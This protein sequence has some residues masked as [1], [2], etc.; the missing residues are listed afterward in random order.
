[1]RTHTFTRQELFDLVWSAMSV[2]ARER[3]ARTVALDRGPTTPWVSPTSAEETMV[4]CALSLG[5]PSNRIASNPLTPSGSDEQTSMKDYNALPMLMSEA[6]IATSVRELIGEARSESHPD[7][8][9]VAESLVTMIGRQSSHYRPF[10]PD[11]AKL[12]DDWVCDVWSTESLPLFDALAT[13]AANTASSRTKSL[14]ERARQ[15]P[16]RAISDI[17]TETLSQ[18]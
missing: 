9:L 14:L 7:L 17:A 6:E 12:I 11:V 2:R 13:L 15:H 10:A 16:D 18:I 5:M 3:R 4:D 8:A 1:M